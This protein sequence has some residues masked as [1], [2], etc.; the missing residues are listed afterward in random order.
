MFE[1]RLVDDDERELYREQ[2]LLSFS[3]LQLCSID[4]Q[5]DLYKRIMQVN[6][7]NENCISHRQTLIDEQ[8]I[9]ERIS[10]RNCFDRNDVL[11]KNEN[12]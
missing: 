12:L 2:V 3:R 7:K 5:D 6:R 8:I 10:L 4:A 9:N 1:F 11:F